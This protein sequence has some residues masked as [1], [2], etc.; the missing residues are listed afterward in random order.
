MA[1]ISSAGLGSGLDVNGLVS[2]LMAFERQPLTDLTKKEASYQA[3]LSAMGNV[4][5]AVSTF[6]G[7][8]R[9]LTD[10]SKFNR[11][12]ATVSDATIATSSATSLAQIGTTRLEVWQLAQAHKLKTAGVAAADTVVGTGTLTIQ[13]GTYNSDDNTFAINPNKSSATVTIAPEKN[14][15]AGVRDAIN[16]ANIG[17]N[18]S[19]V[20]DGGTNGFRLVLASKDSG[21]ANSLKITVSED[22]GSP[23]NTDTSGLSMLAYDPTGT[24]DDGKNL[25][26][27][28]AA[29]DAKLSVDGVMIAKPS[30]TVTD[31]IQ[32]VTLNLLKTTTAAVDVTI[33]RDTSAV[34]TAVQAFVKGYNDLAKTLGDLSAF[35][36][37]SGKAAALQGESVIRSLQFQMRATLNG[38]LG[39][40][41]FTRLSQVGVSFQR[42]GTISVDTAKLA[43]ALNTNA[44]GVA[45]L[46]GAWGVSTESSVKFVSGS[47]ATKPGSHAVNITTLAAQAKLVGGTVNSLT[48]DGSN[49]TFTINVDG[50]G[51]GTITLAQATYA[52]PQ[53]LAA[54]LQSKINGD[55]S[56]KA[57]GKSVVVSYNADTSTFELTSA[58]Y[59]SASKVSIVSGAAALDTTLGLTI[60]S[61]ASGVDVAGTIGGVEATGSGQYLTGNGVAKDLKLQITGGSLGERDPV[62]YNVGLA[63]QLDKQLD[64]M[65]SAKG[66]IAARTE[67][68]DQQIKGVGDKRTTL[69]RRLDTVEANY[70]KQFTAL[71]TLVSSLQRTSSYLS[72]QLANLPKAG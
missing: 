60:G 8:V 43:G 51:S 62:V 25:V 34:T 10:V 26:E 39:Q 44:D 27:T 64:D 35:D 71:D 5:A 61:S 52:S 1:S 49:D 18:A 45:G 24:V 56:L 37:K 17:V 55:S 70:R 16:A 57:G 15:L 68:L 38:V 9:G 13:F 7:S 65:L 54:E 58:R 30:N 48:V 19:I 72:Q 63:A 50:T 66:M 33:S 29:K 23:T 21:A 42:D 31:A 47:S 22:G 11:L 46:F 6:Q 69:N 53:E 59:G 40:G 4:K 67:G 41:S 32:G 3:K 2:Q 36:P 20:N 12:G 28:V 14:T